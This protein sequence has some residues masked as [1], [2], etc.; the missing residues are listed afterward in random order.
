M[1][2]AVHLSEQ[3]DFLAMDPNKL[4]RTRQSVMTRAKEKEKVRATEEK[5]ESIYF[6]GRKD[7]T[8]AMVPDAR[9]QLQ[10]KIMSVT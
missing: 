8:R 9:G 6:D 4:T 10:P 2:V 7:K 5:I 3:M 1:I